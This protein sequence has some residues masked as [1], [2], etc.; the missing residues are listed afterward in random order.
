LSGFETRIELGAEMNVA[1]HLLESFRPP[2]KNRRGIGFSHDDE[3]V[4]LTW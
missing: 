2:L 1:S 4:D 3:W